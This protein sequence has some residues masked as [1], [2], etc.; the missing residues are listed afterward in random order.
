MNGFYVRQ[1]TLLNQRGNGD[2]LYYYVYHFVM[3]ITTTYSNAK[4]KKSMQK[5]YYFA[6]IFLQL[7]P[8]D[9]FS[10]G[11]FVVCDTKW[12]PIFASTTL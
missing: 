6:I 11:S 10:L 3:Y 7:L 12:K 5:K 1:E 8:N 2:D 4:C 9:S